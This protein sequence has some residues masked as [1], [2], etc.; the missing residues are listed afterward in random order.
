MKKF[1]KVEFWAE[2]GA[3]CVRDEKK[4]REEGRDVIKEMAPRRFLEQAQ[5]AHDSISLKYSDEV[6]NG[7][8]LMND[9]QEVARQAREQ[10]ASQGKKARIVV[11]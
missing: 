2:N 8:Q 5:G 7:N 1:G 10:F 6:R 11:P 4:S 9:A 3:V